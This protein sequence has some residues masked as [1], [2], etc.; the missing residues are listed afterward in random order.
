[1]GWVDV[2]D[3][4]AAH[5]LALFT[6]AAKGRYVCSAGSTRFADLAR[7]VSEFFPTRV[8]PP[9]MTVPKWLLWLIGPLAGVPR[10]MVK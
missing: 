3:V 6:P 9:S 1:M 5:S 7:T 4:A 10:D 2:R 8:K